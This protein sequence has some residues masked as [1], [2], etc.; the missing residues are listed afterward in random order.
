M[1]TSSWS[2]SFASE[3]KRAA[4]RRVHAP[5]GATAARREQTRKAADIR[6]RP[7]GVKREGGVASP[8]TY[9]DIR[10]QVHSRTP[11]MF[12]VISLLLM[13]D[14][15]SVGRGRTVV[16]HDMRWENP[17]RGPRVEDNHRKLKQGRPQ[18]STA[19]HVARSLQKRE[20]IICHRRS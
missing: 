13:Y 11:R 8:Y 5:R 6:A 15:A 20:N 4:A 14:R 16:D 3:E 1:F 18:Y 2:L 9:S 10:R 12:L 19:A 7:W 17:E